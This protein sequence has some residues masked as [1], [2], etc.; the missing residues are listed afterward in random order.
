MA[1]MVLLCGAA[2]A[3]AAEPQKWCTDADGQH[4]ELSFSMTA[5]S[6]RRMAKSLNI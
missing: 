5:L 4:A 2:S 6:S 3:D 1:L